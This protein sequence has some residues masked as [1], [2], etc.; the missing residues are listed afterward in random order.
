M[1]ITVNATL[2]GISKTGATTITIVSGGVSG[3]TGFL[4]L[5]GFED[6]ILIG[7]IVAAVAAGVAILLMRKRTPPQGRDRPS[8][9]IADG[10]A[11]AQ[12]V[13]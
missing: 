10:A 11:K 5:P 1:I 2:N 3:S 4:G 8:K 7:V 6:Y 9:N 13:E 12:A